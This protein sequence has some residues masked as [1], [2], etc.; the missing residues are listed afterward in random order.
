MTFTANIW[1]C[2]AG[3]IVFKCLYMLLIT[4]AILSS[5]PLGI[6]PQFTIYG[7]YFSAI[8]VIF[9][10]RGV[11]TIMS[12]AKPQRLHHCRGAASKSERQ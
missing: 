3:D 7:S 10:L 12:A 6:I 1:A 11:Y 5:H 4:I 2:Y 8:A 9:F